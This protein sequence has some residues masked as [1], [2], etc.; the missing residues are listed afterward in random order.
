MTQTHCTGND[1]IINI[2]EFKRLR[3]ANHMGQRENNRA[4]KLKPHISSIE[5][6]KM[7]LKQAAF[8]IGD[9][10]A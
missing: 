8:K 9:C 2:T 10:T 4:I 6:E 1:G 3:Q 5:Y 7:M